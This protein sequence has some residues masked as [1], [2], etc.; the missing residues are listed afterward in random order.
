M[1]NS[2]ISLYKNR[3]NQVLQNI[4]ETTD[5]PA[6]RLKDAIY[7]SLFPG[8]KRLRPVL[9]YLCGELLDTNPDALDIIAASIELMHSFSLVH[10]DLPA[11]DNDDFRRN[12][13]SCHCEFDEATAILVGDGM[14]A[15]AI[16]ILLTKLPNY[17]ELTKVI[18]ITHEL[19]V[20]CGASGMVSGQSL[21]MSELNN[22]NIDE[23]TLYEI[24]LLKTGKLIIA[25]IQMTIKASNPTPSAIQALNEFAKNLGILFQMQDDYLDLYG[26]NNSL[27]KNR[28]SDR[29]NEKITFANI[30]DKNKLA[31]LI[32]EHITKA[33]QALTILGDKAN[34]LLNLLAYLTKRL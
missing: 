5:I 16:D 32:N 29:E 13:L 25:C 26:A 8:G 11:M 7:Y 2:V 24:H 23:K 22:P 3:H 17:L 33:E 34:N 18:A 28:S 1:N 10:D 19:L 4:I 20:A 31:S 9:V 27:G 15:L 12:K 21:D 14:Q 30:H 6:K